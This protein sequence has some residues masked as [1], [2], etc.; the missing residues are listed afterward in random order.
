M[1]ALKSMR[2]SCEVFNGLDGFVVWLLNAYVGNL[3][4]PPRLYM[5]L[6]PITSGRVHW[7]RSGAT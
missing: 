2:I 6:T 1:G 3:S 7:S 4:V 5:A